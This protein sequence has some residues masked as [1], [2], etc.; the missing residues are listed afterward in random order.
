VLV[1]D[2]AKAHRLGR[3][4]PIGEA[5]AKVIAAQQN[6][7]RAMFPDTP[8]AELALL[9]TPRR[10]PHGHTPISIDTLDAR[11]REWISALPVLHTRDGIEKVSRQL[12][13]ISVGREPGVDLHGLDPP[14]PLFTHRAGWSAQPNFGRTFWT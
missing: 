6:R 5:T 2:N 11:H 14:T 9:P 3:R 8:I 4:L 10:N 13:R 12:Q 1:H 7:V